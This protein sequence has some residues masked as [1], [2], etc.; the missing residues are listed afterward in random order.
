[1]QP[2]PMLGCPL[3]DKFLHSSSQSLSLSQLGPAPFQQ[4]PTAGLPPAPQ[5]NILARSR[6]SAGCLLLPTRGGHCRS[7]Q[8][9]GKRVIVSPF[10]TLLS[11]RRDNDFWCQGQDAAGC[12]GVG[13]ASDL[14]LLTLKLSGSEKR[15]SDKFKQQTVRISL[16]LRRGRTAQPPR[17]RASDPG[18]H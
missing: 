6:S 10:H 18:F 11:R 1:M 13:A 7:E 2:P 12:G 9:P 8:S 15:E 17:A 14:T 4:P 16:V 3:K 5:A